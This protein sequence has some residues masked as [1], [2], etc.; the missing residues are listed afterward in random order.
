MDEFEQVAGSCD[1]DHAKEALGELV[2]SGSD[3]SIDVEM[4][5]QALEQQIL[6][7][8]PLRLA[9]IAPAQSRR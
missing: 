6:Q 5:E 7:D 1:L 9:Q 3:G 8:P 2:I 4:T